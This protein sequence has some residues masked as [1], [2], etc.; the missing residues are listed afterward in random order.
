MITIIFESHATSKDNE[1]RRS[2]GHFDVELS[3]KGIEQAKEL[4]KRRSSEHF[5]SYKTAEIAFKDRDIQ[6]IK[7]ERL[8]ECNY[9]DMTRGSSDETEPQRSKFIDKPWPNGESYQDCAKRIRDFL[10]DILKEYD[11]KKVM[12]IGHRA[13]QYGLNN[14][15]NHIPL[16]K[17]VTDPW[18]WQPGWE[19]KL[20]TI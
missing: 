6:I 14:I 12:V 9:G 2:S 20:D 7:D 3:D 16:N 17:A 10:T 15:I 13:T 11:G 4:G 1:S 5:G 19:Y 8:R 18:Q